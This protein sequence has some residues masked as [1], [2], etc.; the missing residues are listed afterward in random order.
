MD[1]PVGDGHIKLKIVAAHAGVSA[2]LESGTAKRLSLAVFHGSAVGPGG[3]TPAANKL[4][5]S[6]GNSMPKPNAPSPAAGEWS[7]ACHLSEGDTGTLVLLEHQGGTTRAIPVEDAPASGLEAAQRPVLVGLAP[8]NSLLMMDAVSKQISR[9]SHLP[10]D[11]VATYAYV[12]PATA[13]YW[14][15]NDGDKDNGVD[16]LNC[17]NSGSPVIAVKGLGNT[18]TAE[19]LKTIC[20]GRGHHVTVFTAPSSRAPRVPRRIFASNLLDGT[21][22]VIGNDPADGE[23]YLEPVAVI[24]LADPRHEDGTGEAVPNHAFPH[25]MAYSPLTGKLYNMNNGYG[26]VAVIDPVTNAVETTVA[27]KVSSNLLLSPDGRF[28]IGKGADRKSDAE[29]VIGRLSIMDAENNTLAGTLELPDIYP[30]VYRFSSDGR[31]LYVT[32]AATGK[33]GQKANLKLDTLLVFDTSALPAIKL[34]K[35]VHVGRADC[36]RRPIAFIDQGEHGGVRVFVPNT[37][38]GT[39]SILDGADDTVLETVKLG[40]T[41]LVEINFSFWTGL[42]YGG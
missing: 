2:A 3:T 17:G 40:K 5:I 27:M 25:G 20:L 36:G 30:S 16:V 7:F 13:T 18:G 12:D 31:K 4:R 8:D 32:T 26:T 21:I 19:V 15:V 22:S 34:I 35:E 1:Q 9:Q 23:T 38:D 37:S 33:G 42:S 10:R 11:A 24:N 41:D 28:L 29:H 6:G 14:M 39:L